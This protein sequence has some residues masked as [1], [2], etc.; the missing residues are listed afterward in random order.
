LQG[1]STQWV[2]E[3]YQGS[4]DEH[5]DVLFN[6]P[7]VPASAMNFD[8]TA[9]Q[10]GGAL[11]EDL[12]EKVR[13]SAFV[14]ADETHWREDGINHYIWYAGNDELAFYLIDPHRSS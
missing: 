2:F 8:R 13:A 5:F 6:M 10:K 14:H 4:D 12:K 11:Y 1:L 3:E 7:F 9:T